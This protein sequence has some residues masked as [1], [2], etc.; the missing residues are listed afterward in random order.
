M[1]IAGDFAFHF[2]ISQFIYPRCDVQPCLP[3]PHSGMIAEATVHE[4]QSS[5]SKFF[6]LKILISKSF[7]KRI[8]QEKFANS[9]VFKDHVQGGGWVEFFPRGGDPFYAQI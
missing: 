4:S 9:N 1:P 3:Q 5:M 2:L 8:L 7:R 6:V